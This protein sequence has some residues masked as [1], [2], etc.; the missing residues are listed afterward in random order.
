MLNGSIEWKRRRKRKTRSSKS[1]FWTC[2]EGLE[3]VTVWQRRKD[4]EHKL[5]FGITEDVVMVWV[6]KF[7]I[8]VD[9]PLT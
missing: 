2:A 5:I 7:A 8:N 3:K 1:D 9:S 6:G 4:Q